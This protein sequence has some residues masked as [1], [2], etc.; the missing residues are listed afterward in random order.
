MAEKK[1][2]K[3]KAVKSE[4]KIKSETYL[5]FK[6]LKMHGGF[7]CHPVKGED[8]DDT[9]FVVY[10]PDNNQVKITAHTD[11]KVGLMALPYLG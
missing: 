9:Q 3:K 1:L 7:I 11:G 8:L 2:E 4:M 5:M 6:N 10:A